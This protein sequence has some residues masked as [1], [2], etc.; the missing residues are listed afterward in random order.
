MHLEFMRIAERQM[1]A[2]AEPL[3]VKSLT[4]WH[5]KFKTLAPLASFRNVTRLTIAGFP[6]E[7]FEQISMLSN[8]KELR[9]LHFPRARS[10]APLKHLVQL[11]ALS[12]ESLPS[13]DTSRRQLVVESLDPLAELPSLTHLQLFGVVPPDR[14]L[15][16]LEANSSLKSARFQGYPAAEAELFFLAKGVKNASYP[17]P[18]G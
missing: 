13:W 11:F 1:P 2:V 7:S 17:F 3:E 18:A 15:A 9:I 14:S 10:L 8:L 6:D 12:L 16:V 5:C 4:V